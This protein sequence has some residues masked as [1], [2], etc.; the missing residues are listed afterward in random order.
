MSTTTTT[1]TRTLLGGL[2]NVGPYNVPVGELTIEPLDMPG[3]HVTRMR[4][5]GLAVA[6]YVYPL[7]KLSED[8][9]V[10][11]VDDLG[12]GPIA[13][14]RIPV[15]ALGIEL[16]AEGMLRG[17]AAANGVNVPTADPVPDPARWENGDWKTCSL[18]G[19]AITQDCLCDPA[20]G[21]GDVAAATRAMYEVTNED[22]EPFEDLAGSAEALYE[23]AARSVI[24]A[25][26]GIRARHTDEALEG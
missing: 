1:P 14:V 7:D 16:M 23:V 5:R 10:L 6:L 15:S 17:Y 22:G 20:M 8:H 11:L 25:Y 2:R 24:E 13:D 18:H 9:R 21:L 19:G 12:I 4:V 3:Q 26:H